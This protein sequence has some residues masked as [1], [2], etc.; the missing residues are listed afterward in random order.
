MIA[1][2]LGVLFPP[3]RGKIADFH[4]VV[5]LAAIENGEIETY[6]GEDSWAGPVFEWRD[7]WHQKSRRYQ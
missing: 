3:K 4:T 1:R 7:G 2:I 6:E 5:L